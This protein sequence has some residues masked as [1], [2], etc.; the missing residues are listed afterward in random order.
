MQRPVDVDR[1]RV[2]LSF[3]GDDRAHALR[4]S[5][6]LVRA[7]VHVFV[8]EQSIRPGENFVLAIERALEQVDYYTLLLSRASVGSWWVEQEWSAAYTRER[9][10][11]RSFLFVVR[12]DPISPPLL[13]A[14]RRYLDAFADWNAVVTQ[15]ASA[16]REDW[17]AR[18]NGAHPRPSPPPAPARATDSPRP[19]LVLY[20]RNHDL[21]VGLVLAVPEHLTGRE[22]E[23][24]VRAV[25]AL[26]DDSQMDIGKM[27]VGLRFHYQL[28][29]AGKPIPPEKPLIECDVEDRATI[30]LVVRK[31]ELPPTGPARHT[32]FRGGPPSAIPP[33]IVDHLMDAAF[34]HLIP[35]WDLR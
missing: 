33:G 18:R 15:L 25:L 26:P 23:S 14:T 17:A 13:L 7:G 2:F 34:G 19:T 5:R 28:E 31:E 9:D 8:Y 32:E 27:T 30:Q 24:R 11:N 20:V 1:P 22:L 4:F 21:S 10:E 6:D 16:F 35:R 3:A 12:L 29:H